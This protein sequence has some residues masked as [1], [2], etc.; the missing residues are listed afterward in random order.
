MQ[1]FELHEVSSVFRVTALVNA[2]YYNLPEDFLF[3]GESHDFWEMIYVD[4]GQVVICHDE[5]SYL[6]KAGEMLF[7][8]P[9]VFHS[10]RVWQGKP[11]A[12][13]NI[14]FAVDG[15]VTVPEDKIICLSAV[16]RQCM[17]V[18][19]REAAQTY[20]HFDDLPAQVR[21][22]KVCSVPYGSEQIICNRLEELMI[23]ACRSGRNIHVE[24]RL[25]T[26]ESP[27]D[28][29]GLADR[30]QSYLQVHFREKLTLEKVAK[31][32]NISISKLKRIFRES[33][34]T[35]VVAHLTALRI[36]E[37]KR[38]IRE[39]NHSFSQI[40]ENVGFESIHYFSTVFKK[41]TGMTPS[42]YARSL[43]AK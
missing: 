7:C 9:D 2:A 17:A 38:L 1:P 10:A 37:A 43:R 15:S 29:D 33:T 18:I 19:V 13:V 27:V 21:L 23:Y 35:S 41:H 14:A 12:I 30:L 16:E 36:K 34:E 6:L 22:A 4:R 5:G 28:S 8:K 11:A 24:S 32:H 39:G 31:A 3:P 40:A 42:D 20:I 25:V 26:T